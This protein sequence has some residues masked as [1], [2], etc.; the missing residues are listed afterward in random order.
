MDIKNDDNQNKSSSISGWVILAILLCAFAIYQLPSLTPINKEHFVGS[1][2]N[3]DFVGHGSITN[4]EGL[5]CYEGTF[6]DSGEYFYYHD[7]N[8]YDYNPEVA[9]ELESEKDAFRIRA[10][11][12]INPDNPN[13]VITTIKGFDKE[14]TDIKALGIKVPVNLTCDPV[15]KTIYTLT[16]VSSVAVKPITDICPGGTLQLPI[17]KERPISPGLSLRYSVTESDKG[18]L[19][20]INSHPI[21]YPSGYESELSKAEV[22]VPVELVCEYTPQKKKI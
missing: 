14:Q 1:V 12:A 5:S 21:I 19:W 18:D 2:N 3:P 22:S 9:S 20:V 6:G 11:H 15:L 17:N 13:E 4:T 7:G 8:L 10:S 16:D